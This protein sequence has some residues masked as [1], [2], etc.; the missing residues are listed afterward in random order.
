LQVDAHEKIVAVGL[1]TERELK[2]VGE[3][4]QR[5]YLVDDDRTFD[6]LLAAI[7]A[8]DRKQGHGTET[9]GGR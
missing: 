9:A 8:A 5:L 4:L 3:S 6:P 7:D 2:L 1:L